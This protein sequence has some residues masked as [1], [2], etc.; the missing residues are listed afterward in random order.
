MVQDS[1]THLGNM[2]FIDHC[3]PDKMLDIAGKQ[4]KN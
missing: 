1:Q 2:Q 3:K 4:N